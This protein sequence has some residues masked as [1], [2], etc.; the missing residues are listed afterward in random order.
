MQTLAAIEQG[1]A[2]RR[3]RPPDIPGAVE[4]VLGDASLA[5]TP[6]AGAAR[7][8]AAAVQAEGAFRPELPYH[9]RHHVAE[10]VMAMGLLCALARLGGLLDA[11]MSTLGVVA[12]VG[13]DR[14]HDGSPPGDGRLE[15]LA[16][17]LTRPVL[18]AAG[19][20]AAE[21]LVVTDVILAT[22]PACV[23]INAARAAGCVPADPR[24]HG[25]DL[26]CQL[27][28][29][30]DVFA[31]LLPSRGWRM[32]AALA[33]EWRMGGHARAEAVASF[34]GRLGFLRL[35]RRFSPPAE[36]LGLSRLV[37]QQVAAFAWGAASPE[38]GAAALDR[39][40]RPA[41]HRRYMD[42]LDAIQE[43]P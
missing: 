29:E 5:E 24:G 21:S 19:L 32:G 3:S 22:D 36:S 7:A 35:Y 37:G 33:A 1:F 39:M 17:E 20:G 23:A 12:M 6:A 4:D 31:S 34:S 11:P 43:A 16:A 18:A 38:E 8:L 30:A 26:L 2:T 15:R 14:G 9:N 40:P 13:H 28:N 10:A 25:F 27:A 41:A 42:A